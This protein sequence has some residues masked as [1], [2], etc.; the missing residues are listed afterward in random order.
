ML[1]G[2]KPDI[3]RVC[4]GI[5]LSY[6]VRHHR[7]TTQ[8]ARGDAVVKAKGQCSLGKERAKSTFYHLLNSADNRQTHSRANRKI[9]ELSPS[10]LMTLIRSNTVVLMPF[11]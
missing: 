11:L 1:R 2:E 7:T 6:P 9:K 10:W 5:V 8:T 3:V 4:V